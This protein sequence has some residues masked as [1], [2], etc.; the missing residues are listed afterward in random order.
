MM[1]EKFDEQFPSKKMLSVLI[2]IGIW[3]IAWASII[4]ALSLMFKK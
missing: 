3:M 1:P 2:V 4:I